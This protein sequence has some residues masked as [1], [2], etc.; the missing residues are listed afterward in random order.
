M[1]EFEQPE[2]ARTDLSEALLTLL[3]Q[4]V[5]DADGFSW[6]EKPPE[7]AIAFARQAL[8]DLGFRDPATGA[9]TAEGREALKLPLPARLARLVLEAA[10]A[11]TIA[12][13]ARLAALLS[14]KDIVLRSSDLKFHAALESDV[15]LRL[16]LL[17]ERR[18]SS[19]AVD[20]VAARN[21]ARVAL[22]L[23][24][25][26]RRLKVGR[27]RL[28]EGASGDELALRLLL[29]A[30]PDR[31]CRR[32]RPKEPAARMVGGRG[33]KLA[34][35]SSVETAEFFVAIDSSEPPPS[36]LAAGGAR[37]VQIS[38]ASRI[39]REWLKAHFPSSSLA[40]VNEVV[41]DGESLSVQKR[42][43]ESF[44]D[45][46]LEEP[47][48][49][50][51]TA[52]EAFAPLVAACRE[53]WEA[54]FAAD[55][56]LSRVLARLKFARAQ[57]PQAPDLDFAS[58]QTAFLEEVC[59]G[60][61]RLSDIK[62]KDLSE[63]FLRHLPADFAS[64]VAEAAPES[65]VVPSGSRIR[66]HYPE[67]RP[68][69]LEVRIQEIFGL[70]ESPRVARGRVPVVLHLLGPNF[71][72]VQVTSDLVSF[73]KNGYAEVRKELRTRYPKHS[74][75]EDPTTATPEAKGRRHRGP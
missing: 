71:R 26:A 5:G 43:A 23:E 57:M 63:A 52:E 1:P 69:Y 8:T 7:S 61:T 25:A 3:A 39:E 72:P 14:E 49:S 50:R 44:H 9:L 59:Y 42:W 19:V 35:F 34:P 27:T 36:A 2:V 6:F 29:L 68:P 22:L 17:D 58:V 18:S 32:R 37:D 16:H 38:I 60:E 46:P 74:W 41:F 70:R 11:G 66:I 24:S 4:G 64:W 53:R 55:E 33:V 54:Q 12:L 56:N 15:V 65:L 31:L 20:A 45:L 10:K 75:P 67:D 40:R 30:Y 73:W 47:H 62:S 48:V 13:G 28:L 21:V 51:P